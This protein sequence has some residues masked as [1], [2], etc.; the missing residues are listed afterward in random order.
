M[1][2]PDLVDRLDTAG[3][4]KPYGDQQKAIETHLRVL[5]ADDWRVR[6]T[7]PNGDAIVDFLRDDEEAPV[8]RAEVTLAG[9]VKPF[10]TEVLA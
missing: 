2:S 5:E 3:M 1:A 7:L 4:L 10:V 6:E 8:A 9:E